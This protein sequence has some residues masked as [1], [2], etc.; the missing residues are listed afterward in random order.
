MSP[1]CTLGKKKVLTTR[2]FNGEGEWDPEKWE[3]NINE[4]KTHRDA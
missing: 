3:L 1:I 4:R 2:T